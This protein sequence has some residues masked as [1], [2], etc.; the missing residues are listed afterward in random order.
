LKGLVY[1]L[2]LEQLS[3]LQCYDAFVKATNNIGMKDKQI[4]DKEWVQGEIKRN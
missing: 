4:A 3:Q 1:P 2:A